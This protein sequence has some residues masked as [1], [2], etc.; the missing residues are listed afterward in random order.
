MAMPEQSTNFN[1]EL[2]LAGLSKHER[3][4]LTQAALSGLGP[5]DLVDITAEQLRRLEPGPQ[6]FPIFK[7]LARIAVLPTYE[8]A[9]VRPNDELESFDIALKK[10]K[11]EVG[12]D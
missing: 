6:P 10:R 11:G 9:A 8:L 2:R 4:H 1:S 12:Q 5:E 3:I 7:E